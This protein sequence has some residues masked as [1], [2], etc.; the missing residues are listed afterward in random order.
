MNRAAHLDRSNLCLYC[1]LIYTDIRLIPCAVMLCVSGCRLYEEVIRRFYYSYSTVTKGICY[2]VYQLVSALRRGVCNRY[3]TRVICASMQESL[4]P[5]C[6]FCRRHDLV[7][8][9]YGCACM[10]T[11]ASVSATYWLVAYHAWPDSRTL[12]TLC[13]CGS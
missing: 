12:Y 7:H 5:Q 1:Y 2:R 4:S 11:Y 13:C 3:V 8:Y 10:A 6:Y 9:G